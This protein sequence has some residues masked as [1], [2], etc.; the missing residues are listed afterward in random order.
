MPVGAFGA[1]ALA[2]RA[3][4]ASVR[5]SGS[6]RGTCGSARPCARRIPLVQPRARLSSPRVRFTKRVF[7]SVMRARARTMSD[8]G[9]AK[10]LSGAPSAMDA[11][12]PADLSGYNSRRSR[13]VSSV[14][15]VGVFHSWNCPPQRPCSSHR[16]VRSRPSSPAAFPN[17]LGCRPLTVTRL[18]PR[19]RYYSAVR[20]L[21]EHPFPLR[22]RL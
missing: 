4:L 2:P 22:S 16:P 10:D 13:Q 14:A 18:S 17:P 1:S 19:F 21:D 20:L 8:G 9:I 6:K 11:P 12:P 7:A 3:P 15:D 5:R